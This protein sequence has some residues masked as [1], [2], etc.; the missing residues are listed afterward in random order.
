MGKPTPALITI[1][2]LSQ[3]YEAILFDAYGVLVDGSGTITGAKELIQH[4]NEI[5]KAYFIVTNVSSKPNASIAESFQR[6]GLEIGADKIISSG[7]LIGEFLQQ[8]PLKAPKCFVIGAP[9]SLENIVSS[10][11][12]IIEVTDPTIP[13]VF[14]IADL[15]R[16]PNTELMDRLEDFINRVTHALR[17]GSQPTLLIGNPDPCYPS[18]P[19]KIGFTPGS[20][21]TMIESALEFEFPGTASSLFVRLGKPYAPIFSKAVEKSGT[22]NMVMIGDHMATD[23]KG[24]NDFG[25][26]SALV[27]F[28]PESANTQ[29]RAATFSP[30]YLLQSF[31]LK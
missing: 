7:A 1:R 12:R 31:N 19:D 2:D 10:G 6:S 21:A 26:D 17:S 16:I 28:S 8:G 27:T 30:T 29:L 14:I 13:D 18:G 24:A 4:L 23:I 25:I 3:K 9:P 22:R 15:T 5:G 20:V 11:A